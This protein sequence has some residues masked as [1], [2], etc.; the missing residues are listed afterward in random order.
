[1]IRPTQ[2]LGQST[3]LT[4]V[5]ALAR[6]V[7]AFICALA[8]LPCLASAASAQTSSTGGVSGRVV[9]SHGDAVAG[10]EVELR[11]AAT[12]ASRRQS[13]DGEGRYA[14]PSVEPG[15]YSLAAGM[16]GFR[17]ASIS[18]LRV[19]VTKSYGCDVR[20][21][22]GDLAET[23]NVVAGG[24]AELQKTDAT[25]GAVVTSRA[26]VGLPSLARD[27]VEFLTLQPGTSPEAGDTDNGSRGGAVTGARTDQSTFTLDGIDVTENSTGG[28][29]GF[30]LMIP[31]PVESVEE[32]RV[33]VSNP[34]ASFGRASGGQ[35]ALVGRR[36]SNEFHGA[37]YWYHQ[38]DGLNA[39]SWTNNRSGVPKGDA[40]DDRFGFRVGGPVRHDRAFF[41]VNYERRDFLRVF[42]V[43][44]VVPTDTLRQGVVR[45]RDN[46][47]RVVSYDLANS[48]LC[49]ATANRRCDPRGL[50]LSPTV[51]AL[52]SLLPRG[53]DPGTGDG[54]NTIGWRSTAPAP[55]TS[56][57]GVARFDYALAPR[58][59]L[60]AAASYS[61][62]LSTF[63]GANGPQQQ[64]DIRGGDAVFTGQSPL[65]GQNVTL[66]LTGTTTPTFT[67]SLR[68]GWT[69]D[70]QASSPVD[71]SAVANLLAVAGTQSAAGRVAINVGGGNADQLVSQPIDVDS[72]RARVQTNDNQ[73]FQLVYDGARGSGRH[74]FQFGADARRVITR[75]VRNDRLQGALAALTA[76]VFR[77]SNVSIPAASRPPTCSA[78]GQT[79]CLRANDVGQWDA[80]FAA[81][82]GMVDNVSVLAARDSDLNTLP[83]GTPLAGDAAHDDYDFYL[84]DTWQ[85]RPSLALTLGLSYS[86]QR[87]PVDRLGRET[88]MIY[89]DTGEPLTYA[90]YIGPRRQAAIRGDIFNPRVAFRPL[91]ASGGRPFKT[92]WNNLAPRVALAWNPPFKDGLFHRITGD[93]RT[94]I[95]G[96][97]A[98]LYDRVNT[99][100]S[101]VIPMLSAGFTQ[102]LSLRAPLCNAT[103]AG[104][105]GCN[106]A[107]GSSPLSVFRVGVDGA[108][109]VPT[110]PALSFP[111]A[112]GQPFGETLSLQIDPDFKVGE[113]YNFDLTVQRQLP[114]GMS[115]EIGWI[116][117]LGRKLPAN[118]NFN[119]SPYFQ[120]D[121]RSGQTFAQAFDAVALSLRAGGAGAARAPTPWFQNNVPGGTA[122]AVTGNEANFINGNVSSVFQTIDLARLA[123][124]L[125]PFNNLQTQTAFVRTSTGRSD[126]NALVLLLRRSWSDGLSAD[127]NYTL[128][129]SLDQT[130][131]PENATNS[132]QSAFAPD[133]DYGPSDFDRTHTFNARFLYELPAGRGRRIDAGRMD[134][135]VGGWSLAGIFRAA[136][137]LPLVVSQGVSALGGGTSLFAASGA[138]PIS[139]LPGTGVNRG[140]AGSNN[141][142]TNGDPAAGGS[143]VNLFADP[144][145]ALNSFRRILISQDGRSGR[146]NPLRG[147]P[148]WNL[149]LSL[150]KSARLGERLAGRF[151]LDFFN[152]FNHPVFS[153]PALD[154]TNP[155]SFGVVTQQTVPTRRESSSRWVQLGLRLDF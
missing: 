49:S 33:A 34:N 133:F 97:F 101:V 154:L 54:L 128:S 7:A 150:A 125:T 22:A 57:Y 113:S 65:R 153:N 112:P 140:V 94:V 139:G 20:L 75:S 74:S 10:A 5:R 104:G 99:F 38:G 4:L 6:R 37:G 30:R 117:R 19:E 124:G 131:S 118:V 123:S 134:E 93:R 85:A 66:G 109:P 45:L 84:Q 1:M 64:L 15:E 83:F 148:T 111:Y 13:S 67:H 137:G 48:T 105:A 78:A 35:V 24:G 87:P 108:L 130:S 152:V 50:G 12:G 95:R 2:A 122:R 55:L 25:V 81:V 32:F 116:G 31:V 80:L 40:R 121:A 146:S 23:V 98:V 59:T 77:G 106:P 89:A 17:R 115:F 100:E 53:N 135:L 51:S 145:A 76:S 92:D 16:K 42:D 143:G 44:R 114:R 129:K 82:T 88:R 155:R 107:G 132:M 73:S 39:N 18:G 127:L 60:N 11:N 102:T 52:W 56:D 14:F 41:F 151:S 70:R 147:F 27:A 29:A 69:R 21:E 62:R 26:L 144:G 142:G 47:G 119:S 58:W 79:N 36:G 120:L 71:P 72:Q 96:G 149:D 43:V 68:L 63:G 138:I 8:L 61:R 90:N 46:A 126:Y 3:A 91:S 28:G 110:L 103:G 141:V 136:S 9:D 86:W